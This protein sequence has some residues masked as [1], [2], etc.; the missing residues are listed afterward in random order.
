MI[1]L[2]NTCKPKG[3][4][5]PGAYPWCREH[6]QT[7]RDTVSSVLL[8][9]WYVN[10]LCVPCWGSCW[11]GSLG[12]ADVGV[13][14]LHLMGKDQDG[15]G[16]WQALRGHCVL[17][18][19]AELHPALHSRER[20]TECLRVASG[21]QSFLPPEQKDLMASSRL[22]P[23]HSPAPQSFDRQMLLYKKNQ[24]TNAIFL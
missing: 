17:A 22:E 13:E 23:S 20:K 12:R 21:S 11:K 14:F 4:F 16:L 7:G 24:R 18:G 19:G 8:P 6:L 3:Y 5:W 9:S 1:C 2:A 10:I 15:Q